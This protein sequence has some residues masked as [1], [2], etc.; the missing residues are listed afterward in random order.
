MGLKNA[1]FAYFCARIL[2]NP[3]HISHQNLRIYLIAKS[4]EETK[5]PT[6][7]TKKALFGYFRPTIWVFFGWNLT[8]ILLYL[9]PAQSNLFKRKISR[10]NK[11]A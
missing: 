10:E 8:K 6:F 3:C 9:K 4:C 1:L 5:M 7:G 2:N 11:N